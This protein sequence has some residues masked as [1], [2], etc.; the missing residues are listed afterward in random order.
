MR[1]Q[2]LQQSGISTQH[3]RAAARRSLGNITAAREQAREAWAFTWFTDL[4]A[5][6]R[7][8]V[9][10]LSNSPGFATVAIATAAL[11]IGANTSI[12]SIV[13]AVLLRQLPYKDAARLVTAESIAKD[14]FL[15]P[16]V[17]DFQY[18]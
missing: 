18:G 12:F 17:A 4:A 16:R 13:Q 2:D 6:L 8:A 3:A 7:Y 11:G 1:E 10:S 9:R 15:G 5:D 14:D